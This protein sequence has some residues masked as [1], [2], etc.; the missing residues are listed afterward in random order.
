M[1]KKE[2][3]PLLIVIFFLFILGSGLFSGCI[4]EGTIKSLP[5]TADV[6]FISNRETGTRRKEIF[7]L[8]ID[9]GEI[10]RLTYSDKHF[11]L[12]LLFHL[13]KGEPQPAYPN[14]LSRLH[15]IYRELIQL[16]GQ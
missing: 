16:D 6:L 9:S 12:C 4:I 5:E 14:P 2:R 3:T 15:P 11:F 13:R 8:D 10:T 1:M 7:S